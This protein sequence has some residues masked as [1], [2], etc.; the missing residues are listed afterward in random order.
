MVLYL[1]DSMVY[2]LARDWIGVGFH[3]FVLFMLWSGYATLRA[4]QT[5]LPSATTQA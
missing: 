4:I 2:V 5:S 3:A 1:A